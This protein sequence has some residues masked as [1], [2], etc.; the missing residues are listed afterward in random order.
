MNKFIEL[1]RSFAP[2]SKDSEFNEDVYE[3]SLYFGVLGK[4][5]WSDLHQLR[6]VIILAEAGAGK[7]EEIQAVTK[8]LRDEGKKAFFFRLEHLCSNFEG[9]FEIGTASEFEKWLSSDEPC[10]F[11][12]DSVDEARLVGP[13]NFEAAIRNFGARLGDSK[14]RSHIF[15]TSRLSEWR[16]QSDLSLITDHLS[17]IESTSTT[18][19]Q[20]EDDSGTL[21]GS[22]DG[23]ITSVKKSEAK[24][25]E[26]SVFSL[27]PLDQDQI[28][29]FSQAYGVQ[30]VDAFLKALKRAEADIFS[31]RPLD[32]VDLID[33]WT[34]SGKIA[35]RAELIESSIT[36]KLEEADPDRAAALP[37]T[38]E[39]ARLGA[40]MI[41]AAVSFQR[42]DRILVPEQNIDPGIKH[43]SID[44]RSVLTSWDFD[45]IRAI[46]Q[47]PIFDKAI[48]GTV[49]F[50]HRSVR[51]YLT[52]KWLHWLLI[53]RKSR[54]VIENL[55]F[56]EIYGQIVLVPSMRSILS[57]LILFDDRIRKR[58]EELAPEAFIQ[59]GD[60][61][62]LPT[63]IRK[64]MMERFC[65][66]YS[67]QSM[68]DL[69]FELSE[70]RRFAHKDLDNTINRLL[71]IY[72][73]NEDIRELLLRIVWQGELRGC[74][75]KAL[76]VALDDAV[77]VYTRV[78]G[79]RAI[80]AAGSEDQKNTLI[81]K[82]LSDPAFRREQLIA[83]LIDAFTPDKLSIQDILSLLERLEKSADHAY[84]WIDY[85]LKEFCHHK[86]SNAD[87]I[88]WIH[89]LLPLIKQPPVI[90]RRYFEVSQRHGWLLPFALISAERLV[91][92][93]HPNSLDDKVLEIISL[94]QVGHLFHDLD[95]KE[96]ALADLAP[97]WPE[98]NRALFW[99]DVNAARRQLDKKKKE[100]LTEW[101]QTGMFKHFW[102]FTEDDYE[103][104]LEDIRV[105]SKMDDR[106]V[107]LSL[108]LQIYKE[109]GRDRARRQMLKSAVHG[110]P[111]LEEALNRFLHPAP[112]SDNERSWRRDADFKRRQKERDKKIADNKRDWYEWLQSHTHVLR[113]TSIASEGKIWN[114]TNYLMEELRNKRENSNGWAKSNW[115][116][117]IPEFG[118]DVAEAYRDGCIDYWRKYQP[119]I[120]SE[121]I[122]N[123]NSILHAVIVGLSGLEMEARQ[124]PDWPTTMSE[125][126]A[127]LACRYSLHEMNG[128]PDWFRR[129][130]TAFPDI[131]EK[132]ILAEIKWEFSQY[133]G[134]ESCHYVL[135]DVFW[136]LEWIKPRISS[137]ILP[138]LEI[139]EPKHDDTVQKAVGIIL[140]GP[141]LD[142]SAFVGIARTK[143][144]TSAS[145]YRQ[146]LWLAAWM[147][148][149]AKTAL[150]TLTSI[151]NK[152]TEAKQATDFSLKFIVALLGERRERAVAEYQDFV[153]PEILLSFIK[154]MYKHIR[155]ED[156][157]NRVGGGGDSPTLRDDAQ[158]ARGRLF[159][160]LRDIPGKATY[161]AMID[162]AEHHPNE[163][164]RQR[165]V[166]HA[167][168]RAEEDAE[169]EPWLSGDIALFAEEAERAPQNH[170]ELY[171]LAISRL[172]DLKSDLEDGDT[173]LAE[174]LISVKEERKHR[175]M[176]GGWLRDR[177]LGRY[178]VPQE[179]ELADRKKPDIRIYGVGFDGPV[180]I[181]LKVADNW[182]G[183]KLVERLQNQL[184]GQYLRDV[185]SNC[186]IFT[187]VYRG[188]QKQWQHPKTGN[189]LDF[190]AL[191][192]LL[193]EDAKEIIAKD[194]KIESIRIIDIDL[195]KRQKSSNKRN[196]KTA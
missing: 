62:A 141:D 46:L 47:R 154:L 55:F 148:V 116:D 178:S 172:L 20:D 193:E 37:L 63:E 6:R 146:I 9:S 11:F 44:A 189:Q 64:N 165:Y 95:W 10:W 92:I 79:I 99:F 7:T 125:D 150:E 73:H 30:D 21:D 124:N 176:I 48:Y 179:D 35:N 191:V 89:G 185:R 3:F 142:R 170:R 162:L 24:V 90:E 140:S 74:S 163:P 103:A 80:G 138:F 161:L 4:K 22:S 60:P 32:L 71:E 139:Y 106:L 127:K 36:S 120:R 97:E 173:S 15:I 110:V 27:L 105:K 52:A 164:T 166:E 107:A 114:A 29:T 18:E 59:G 85:Y 158:N 112:M 168:R 175:N 109:S 104:V 187:L 42:K 167:K 195:T 160:L 66:I 43:G 13:K 77:D 58:T 155:I 69:S 111:E 38:A 174:I 149:E 144:H 91:H 156:D 157:I 194:S 130:H 45:Q 145:V 132:C 113:D 131:V 56:R 87:I 128:F 133:D 88:T 117:L 183:P 188:E 53:N 93:R 136:Q 196:I 101:W 50:H 51:E 49:R 159:Q 134:E 26:P 67:N 72:S 151:L 82:L 31:G 65:D 108:A 83:E 61:S 75:E 121:G 40:E 102:R 118:Q 135:D 81:T 1:N 33:Y 115:Q 98:L 180:P 169:A 171:D 8:R 57:W 19:E 181:E 70:V 186:G 23:K 126:E 152:I 122:G 78:C 192:R 100:R 68:A 129:L 54:R 119:R 76:E 153:H 123:P 184:C 84:T 16:A 39:D 86:C 17:F 147:R 177:S 41:A 137:Q 190:G 25:T 143:V 182:S 2:I 96:H 12:L 34:K 28:R 94:A 14:Q 5:K